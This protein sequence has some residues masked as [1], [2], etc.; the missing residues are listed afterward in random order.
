M[1]LK[2]AIHQIK[3]HHQVIP[4]A[5]AMSL[6]TEHTFPRHSHDEFG[7]GIFIQGSQHSWS[8]IGR[9]ESSAGDII[10]VNPAEI[11]DD[12]PVQ[13]ARSWHMIYIN[14]AVIAYELREWP[15]AE[16]DSD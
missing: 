16:S 9:V 8:N 5:E 13:G 3:L 15:Q 6:L 1:T 2:R 14:P 12:L 4:G 11:H 7:I 10:M